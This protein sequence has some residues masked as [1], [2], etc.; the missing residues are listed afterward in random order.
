MRAPGLQLRRLDFPV[1]MFIVE[2]TK[3]AD[4]WLL[5]GYFTAV[6]DFGQVQTTDLSI[7]V[8]G[9]VSFYYSTVAASYQAYLDCFNMKDFITSS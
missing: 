9:N 3:A 2:C 7:S 5:G 8:N 1:T 6:I 4:G